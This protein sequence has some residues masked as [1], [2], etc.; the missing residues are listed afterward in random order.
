MPGV[1]LREEVPLL[2][3]ALGPDVEVEGVPGFVLEEDDADP[4]VAVGLPDDE[5]HADRGPD[6]RPLDR[7]AGVLGADGDVDRA[8]RSRSGT[9]LGGSAASTVARENS[10]APSTP[11][12]MLAPSRVANRAGQRNRH[13]EAPRVRSIHASRR[14]RFVDRAMARPSAGSGRRISPP[15]T[16]SNVSR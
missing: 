16:S 13:R 1:V 14:P 9:D 10:T 15:A 8:A 3:V 2:D 12:T 6:G 11:A 4:P 7:L 5:L